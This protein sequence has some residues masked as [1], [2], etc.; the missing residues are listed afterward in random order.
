MSQDLTY[1]RKVL[2]NCE[3]VDTPFDIKKGDLVRYIT[4]HKGG[5]F[6]YDGG[7]YVKMSD[8]M[9]CLEE[10]E[11]DTKVPICIMNSGGD[12]LYKTRFFVECDEK[13]Q[14]KSKQEYEKIIKNQQRIIEVLIKKNEQLEKK[15]KDNLK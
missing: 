15:I 1:I 5:E 10:N 7:K 11:G 9:V 3:E 13:C 4:I 12:I 2:K 6:F 14:G 8:N